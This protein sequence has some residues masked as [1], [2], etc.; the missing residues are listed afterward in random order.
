MLVL[1]TGAT[2]GIGKSAATIFAKNGHDLIVTGRRQE[3]LDSLKVE[4]EE[5]FN[6]SVTTLCFDIRNYNETEKAISSLSIKGKIDILINNAGLAAGLSAIQD[7]DLDHWE[8]MI[9]TNVKGL[10]YT[11][12]LVSNLMIPNKK[13]HIINIGSI[14]GKEV[15]ANGNVYCATK[16]A[17]DALN[18]A[19]RIDL[20]QHHIKVTAVN[21]GMVETEFSVVRFNGDEERAKKVYAGIEPLNPDDVA[22]TIYWIATRPAHVNINDIVI[23][24]A[25]QATATNVN[26]K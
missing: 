13:G 10:L 25:A 19:M 7:G 6:V 1:I 17:V 9:D 15:Y 26:R 21:P 22:E 3:R 18:K 8:R 14:A 23:M 11:T 4:L 16:H 24:P 20:L 12:R 5:I 2:S